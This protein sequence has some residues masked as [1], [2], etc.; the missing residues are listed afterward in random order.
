[1]GADPKSSVVDK[2]N[3]S[4]DVPN[5]YIVDGSVLATGGVVNPTPT[6]C[7]LALRC[8]ENLRD[9]FDELS[10]NR[11]LGGGL[12]RCCRAAARRA[13][14]VGRRGRHPGAR[15][16]TSTLLQANLEHHGWRSPPP[17]GRRSCARTPRR[18]NR[19]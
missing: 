19:P 8:A 3:R 18:T 12:S 5:L 7:A 10:S 11:A 4:W 1:M 2:W 17:H 16:S 13:G 9:N 15:A 6:I 14:H